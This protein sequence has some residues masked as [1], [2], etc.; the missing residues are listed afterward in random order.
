MTDASAAGGMLLVD[1]P[2]DWTSHDVVAVLRRLFPRGTKVGHTGT[3]DPL[4][5]GLLAVL[6]GPCTRLQSRLQGFD[7][8][9]SGTI[10]LGV[11]TETG[12]IMGKVLVEKPLPSLT[13]AAL[14]KELAS[15]VGT[16]DTPAPAYSAVKHKGKALYEYAREGLEVPVKP[17]SAKVYSWKALAW[18]AP[19]LTHRVACASGTYVRSIAEVLGDRLGCGATVSS[20]RRESIGPFDIADALPLDSARAL[21]PAALAE[22]LLYSLPA[23]DRALRAAP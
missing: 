18:D 21:T 4:A 9:Y 11:K 6:V 8:V 10:R 13:L 1:K 23:L 3:L 17:R 15:L 19:E 7:K 2:R 12:D 5:T 14:D 16:I 22:R 20:L